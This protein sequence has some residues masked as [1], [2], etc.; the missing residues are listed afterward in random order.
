MPG[1]YGIGWGRT[2][3]AA[4]FGGKRLRRQRAIGDQAVV[5]RPPPPSF[6]IAAFMLIRPVALDDFLAAAQ[7][8]VGKHRQNFV[9]GTSAIKRLNQR[10]LQG[11][12]TVES[13][14]IAPRF[15]VMRFG[16]PPLADFRSLVF[17]KTE[18]HADGSFAEPLFH[19]QFN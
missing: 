9:G 4:S 11:N 13:A 3:D 17:V 7:R 8:H 15:Q 10:L 18:V 19:A 12:G 5:Y 6:E 2:S 1:L 14:P 16:E